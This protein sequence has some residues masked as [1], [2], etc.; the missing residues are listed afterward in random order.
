MAVHENAPV[1]GEPATSSPNGK[2]AAGIS[3][4]PPF[5]TLAIT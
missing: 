5:A 1:D 4:E 3:V 2:L